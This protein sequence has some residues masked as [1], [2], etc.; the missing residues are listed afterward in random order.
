MG[1]QPLRKIGDGASG[2]FCMSYSSWLRRR[3]YEV[4]VWWLWT[5]LARKDVHCGLDWRASSYVIQCLGLAIVKWGRYTMY[6]ICDNKRA[7]AVDLFSAAAANCDLITTKPLNVLLHTLVETW[8]EMR[9]SRQSSLLCSHLISPRV[10]GAGWLQ[11]GRCLFYALSSSSLS[12]SS[13]TD[14]HQ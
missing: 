2:K 7:I 12:L 6:A 3:Q 11:N 5:G 1:K 4:R 13:W 14:K 10:W 9:F 8:D